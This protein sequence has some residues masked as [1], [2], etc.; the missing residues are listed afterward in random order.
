MGYPDYLSKT[1]HFCRFQQPFLKQLF[2]YPF[3]IVLQIFSNGAAKFS[4]NL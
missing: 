1:L 2:F 3:G 4:L